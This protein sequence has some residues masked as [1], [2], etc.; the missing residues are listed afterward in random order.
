MRATM[1]LRAAAII[2]AAIAT[3]GCVTSEASTCGD[4]ICPTGRVCARGACVDQ[5]VVTACSRLIEGDSCSV[6]DVGSGTCQGGM[7]LVGRCGDGEINAIDACDGEDLGGKTC[8]D[9]GSERSEGLKCAADCSFDKSG[10]VG[11]CGD[12]VV[13]PSEECDGAELGDKS[14][15]SEGFYAGDL[16]CTSDCTL[17]RGGCSKR[18]GDGERNSFNEQCDGQDFGGSSCARRGFLGD[19]VE[20][21]C[22]E[23]CALDVVSCTCGGERCARNT[24]RCALSDGI[25]TCEAVP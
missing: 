15:I 8:R 1:A 21:K 4:L 24:Q 14:C 17:N 10:C 13:Q 25:Y 9:F 3:A 5:S 23:V 19:V 12:G 16:V 22:T 11:Y 20:L 7:C 2:L 6:V 18:C